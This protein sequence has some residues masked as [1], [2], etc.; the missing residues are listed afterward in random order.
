MP[1]SRAMR[2]SYLTKEIP[3]ISCGVKKDDQVCFT[4]K[5]SVPELNVATRE[6]RKKESFFTKE[7]KQPHLLNTSFASS[8]LLI[9]LVIWCDSLKR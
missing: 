8:H 2:I 5:L 3:L 4:E 7:K 9:V 1:E 6:G